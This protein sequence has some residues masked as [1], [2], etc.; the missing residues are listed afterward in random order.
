MLKGKAFLTGARGERCGEK[1][2]QLSTEDAEED[3]VEEEEE[4]VEVVLWR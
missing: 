1:Q 2:V 3:I 4:D